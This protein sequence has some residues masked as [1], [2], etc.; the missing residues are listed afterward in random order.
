MTISLSRFKMLAHVRHNV[1]MWCHCA[2]VVFPAFL[3]GTEYVACSIESK[4]MMF[5]CLSSC[6]L[7]LHAHLH[8]YICCPHSLLVLPYHN[9]QTLSYTWTI[10]RK[11]MNMNTDSLS[12][13]VPDCLVILTSNVQISNTKSLCLSLKLFTAWGKIIDLEGR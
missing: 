5:K 3:L 10:T 4:I 12:H 2:T 13:R 1:T 11:P 7:S 8:T 9:Y 6:F